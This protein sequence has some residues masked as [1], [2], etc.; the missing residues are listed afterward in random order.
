MGSQAMVNKFRVTGYIAPT[1]D[2]PS[3]YKYVTKVDS[4]Q[5]GPF[6]FNCTEDNASSMGKGNRTDLV[7]LADDIN[8]G[9]NV[10]DIALAHPSSFIKYASGIMKYYNVTAMKQR[11]WMTELH[12]FWGP[13]GTG[14]FHRAYEEARNLGGGVYYPALARQG[15]G[16]G[17]LWWDGYAGE[18][19]VIFDD[20]YGEVPMTDML[21]YVDKYPMKIQYKGGM[22]EFLARRIYITSN[23]A[24]G[25]WWSNDTY[26]LH[27]DAFLRRI[28]SC[29]HLTEKY[30]G[31]S[32]FAAEDLEQSPSGTRDAP[33]TV[34]SDG[35]EGQNN[36]NNHCDDFS[37]GNAIVQQ[38]L[39]RRSTFELPLS[40]DS[41]SP[42][43]RSNA[44]RFSFLNDVDY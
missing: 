3:A 24:W 4:R 33:I 42:P 39:R 43:S 9:A 37:T 12:I 11:D 2:W 15:H 14:K 26:L 5:L 35:E 18:E 34:L 28:T 32:L 16:D 40:M 7:A 19:S 25:N 30:T 44:M 22:L 17:R 38:E 13:T 29:H 36:N 1:I 21:R 41:L 20:F 6:Y 23:K 27:H 8:K 10:K 31:N